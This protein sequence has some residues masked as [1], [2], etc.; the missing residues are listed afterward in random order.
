M[1]PVLLDL[2]CGSGGAGKGYADA[3]F[4]VVGVDLEPQPF[5][6]FPF[7][8]QDALQFLEYGVLSVFSA[9]H[10]SPPCQH[11]SALARGNNGNQ[12]DYPELIEPTRRLLQKTGLPFVIE[13]VVGAPLRDPVQL[14]GEMFGLPVIRHRRFETNWPLQQPPHIKHRGRVAGCRHGEWFEGPYFAVHGDGGGKGSLADWQQA[15]GMPWVPQKKRIAQAI[16]PA[17]TQF[18]GKE[19]LRHVEEGS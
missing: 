19:L 2:F 4:D 7:I 13:N 9:I 16:P 18:I 15:M 14:C 3:G 1:R 10:A 6:P 8:Q 12:G 17:Y 11:H 5:Y